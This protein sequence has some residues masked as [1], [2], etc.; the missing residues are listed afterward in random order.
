MK[1]V[2]EVH[3]CPFC[4][5]KNVEEINRYSIIDSS[6]MYS[7]PNDVLDEEGNLVTVFLKPVKYATQQQFRCYDCHSC[8][9]IRN[10]DADIET[11]K[12]R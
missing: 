4:K 10:Y 7:Q 5:S 11:T 3:Q 6:S 2:Q 9:E 12:R 8:F 1:T